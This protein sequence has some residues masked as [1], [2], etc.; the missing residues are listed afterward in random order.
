MSRF[1]T[2][3]A[4]AQKTGMSP[5]TVRRL[6]ETGALEGALRSPGGHW[7]VPAASVDAWLQSIGAVKKRAV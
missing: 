1:V 4:I 7:R 6:L 2:T 5:K 3:S